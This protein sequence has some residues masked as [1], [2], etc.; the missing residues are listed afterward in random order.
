MDLKDRSCSFACLDRVGEMSFTA[1]CKCKKHV[2][3]HHRSDVG[4]RVATFYEEKYCI[5]DSK[6]AGRKRKIC[7]A[8][9]DRIAVEEKCRK[10]GDL[11]VNANSSTSVVTVSQIDFHLFF[12]FVIKR[13]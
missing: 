7:L 8:C 11:N 2:E 13:I 4:L 1:S 5:F 12:F 9:R 3:W 10:L 6:H